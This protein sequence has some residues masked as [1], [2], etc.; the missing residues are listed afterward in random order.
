M[1]LLMSGLNSDWAVVLI[2]LARSMDGVD[3]LRLMGSALGRAI[4][5][6]LASA[7]LAIESK[8][9]EYSTDGRQVLL[10]IDDAERAS[11]DVWDELSVIADQLGRPSGVSALVV[12]GHTE[13][14]RAVR[15][16]RYPGFAPFFKEHI[17][18]G[19]LD[20]DEARELIGSSFAG[21]T[22]EELHRDSR[23]NPSVLWK[24]AGALRGKLAFEKGA[25]AAG[26]QTQIGIAP[27][28]QASVAP[29][30]DSR[31]PA[32]S[33]IAVAE[34]RVAGQSAASGRQLPRALVPS[35][36]PIRDEDG[37]VEVGWAGDLDSELDEPETR[38]V[39][40]AAELGAGQASALAEEPISDRYAALQA[41][42]EWTRAVD[43]D[44][45]G[46]NL[47]PHSRIRVNDVETNDENNEGDEREAAGARV[48]AEANSSSGQPRVRV[49]TEHDH[50][51]YSELFSRLRQSR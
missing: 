2:H 44:S 12:V 23:G 38:E 10:V 36:P 1:E 5:D 39:A 41:R 22:L 18:L 19:P 46:D 3:M 20:L 32:S 40:L 28:A 30:I 11:A 7:R 27:T 14:A 31:V 17:H 45:A 21:V 16:V 4:P 26:E 43:P 48:T 34:A 25:S 6:Q 51:P 8:L 13:L 35:R 29:A 15:D 37:L 49:E 47:S 42:S 9:A 24:L 33:T 50:G